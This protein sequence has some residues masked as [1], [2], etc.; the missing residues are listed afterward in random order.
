MGDGVVV[1]GNIRLVTIDRRVWDGD[2][3][4]PEKCRMVGRLGGSGYVCV[5]S[6]FYCGRGR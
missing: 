3:I 4:D 6:V 1:F 5:D 2:R